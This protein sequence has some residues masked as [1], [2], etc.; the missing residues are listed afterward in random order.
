MSEITENFSEYSAHRY[1][2]EL[3]NHW[4]FWAIMSM[5]KNGTTYIILCIP[6]FVIFHGLTEFQT[7]CN[8]TYE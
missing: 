1:L 3:N 7:N 2:Y 4:K 6:V 5:C 8:N